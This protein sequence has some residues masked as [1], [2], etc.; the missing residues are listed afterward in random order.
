MIVTLVGSHFYI[1]GTIHGCDINDES[2]I[3]EE[4][5]LSI[6]SSLTISLAA[7]IHVAVV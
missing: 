5:A 4:E 2:N 6:E 3:N 1:R 7:E